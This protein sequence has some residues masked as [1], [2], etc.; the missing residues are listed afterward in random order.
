MKNLLATAILIFTLP[1]MGPAQQP[2]QH[3]NLPKSR[4]VASHFQTPPPEYGPTVT[5]GW[6]GPVTRKVIRRDLDQIHALGFPAVTIEA[7]YRMNEPYLSPGWFRLIRDAAEEAGKRN[8][9]VWL[10]DEGKYPTGFANGKFSQERPDLRMQVLVADDPIHVDPGQHIVQT[11]SSNAVSAAAFNTSDSSTRVLD[12]RSGQ[13]D[14]TAPTDR[15]GWDIRVVEHQFRTSPTRAVNNPTGAKDTANSLMN[16]LNPA[17][18]R[19]F[20]DWTHEQYQQYM[21]SEFGKV[22]LGFRSDEPAY[23][24]MPWTPTLPAAFQRRKGYDVRPYLAAFFVPNM[25][26]EIRR[27]KADYWDVWTDLYQENFFRLIARWCDRN[28]LEY[29][30]HLDKDGPETN[31]GMLDLVRTEGDFFRDMRDLQ[32][33][34][35]DAIWNQVWPGKVANFPKLASSAAHLFGRPRSFSESFAAYNPPPTIDQARWAV[36]Y[37][38]ARGI[39]F[40]EF[41]FYSSSAGGHGGAHG[42]MASDQFPDLAAYTNRASFLLSQGRPDAQIAV[43]FPTSSLWL[44][45]TTANTGTWQVAQQLIEHQRDFDFVDDRTLA[46]TLT[47]HNGVLTNHSG[48]SYRAIILVSPKVI[49]QKALDR[50]ES[51]ANSGG[52]VL[53]LGQSPSL[54]Q[55][56]TFRDASGPPDLNWGDHIPAVGVSSKV[57]NLLLQPA[58]RLDTPAPHLQVVHRQWDGAE[59][60]FFFNESD[61]PVTR[62]VTLTGPR[63]VE[64]WNAQTGDIADIPGVT[65]KDGKVQLSLKLESHQAR[66]LV[67]TTVAK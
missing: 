11:L 34:G 60:Y 65:A 35:V 38:L 27:I 24:R 43:Y 53:F 41:M 58:V 57:L 4:E 66:F 52:E 67:L 62:E 20:M 22:I 14:W 13:L 37:Q 23:Y 45:D 51:F 40:F 55:G 2:W 50:L 64:S 56:R 30:D 25:P 16:Y 5:W 31:H 48:Q 17:A 47:L 18:T 7:G 44:Q 3:I 21:G 28:N 39:N 33:P 9:R 6:S 54:V 19:Q 26:E 61:N 49:S 12:I 15:G 46:T 59:L 36:N 1:T 32:I 42:Y 8:M 63:R 10:I 29:V